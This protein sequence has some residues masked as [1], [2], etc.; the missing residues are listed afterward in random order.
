MFLK[1]SRNNFSDRRAIHSLFAWKS[2]KI[3]A[4]TGNW[5]SS[6]DMENY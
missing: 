2:Q 1:T 3:R 4:L 5:K 6:H